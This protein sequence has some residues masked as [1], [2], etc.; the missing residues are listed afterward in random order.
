MGSRD[1]HPIVA[2]QRLNTILVGSVRHRTTVP[3]NFGSL[4]VA[5]MQNNNESLTKR[6]CGRGT[7][8]PSAKL[9]V[10]RNNP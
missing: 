4:P 6:S 10:M 8:C 5:T 1:S 7:S 2:N 9:G 3:H